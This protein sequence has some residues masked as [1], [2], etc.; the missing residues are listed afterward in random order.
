MWILH[1]DS[2]TW[3]AVT[4]KAE[5]LPAENGNSAA[6]AAPPLVP[7]SAGHAMA[8]WKTKLLIVG[9]H[10]KVGYLYS[11]ILTSSAGTLMPR[12]Q[13]NCMAQT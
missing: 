13:V 11:V 8:A 3:E 1:L 12:A 10:M 2:L 9:G 6:A 5:Q 7:P 4:P